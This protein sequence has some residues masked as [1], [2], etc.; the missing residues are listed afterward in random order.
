MADNLPEVYA[1]ETIEQL[2]AISDA[3]RIRIIELLSGQQ[4]TVTQLGEH[5]GIAPAKV[6]YH[7]RELERVGLLRL[8]ETREKGGVLEKYYRTLA[9]DY[10]VPSA[11]LRSAPPDEV[12]A[13]ITN[14]LSGMTSRLLWAVE[15]KLREPET[16]NDPHIAIGDD[17]VYM[18]DEEVREV[19]RQIQELLKP[20]ESPR[21]GDGEHQHTVA[22]FVHPAEHR[23]VAES[24]GARDDARAAS[25]EPKAQT[26]I[27]AGAFSYSRRDLE[28]VLERG[29]SLKLYVL[30]HLTFAHD[31][32]AELV[33]QA[34][35]S[36]RH[37]GALSAAPEVRAVL[38]AKQQ[39]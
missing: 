28:S 24:T 29:Q 1:L 37:R 12:L 27:I 26:V 17:T 15:S 22:Y 23:E 14:M 20:Y 31:V 35:A 2:R 32:S 38:K 18:T 25:S 16:Q 11:L 10:R 21:G 36:L 39:A 34:I 6:H 8:V 5:L 4:M 3:L 13:V 7:V 9:R 30:G 19:M 33:D